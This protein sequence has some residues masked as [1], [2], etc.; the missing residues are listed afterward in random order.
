MIY[1]F[2]YLSVSGGRGWSGMNKEC[3]ESRMTE[4]YSNYPCDHSWVSLSNTKNRLHLHRIGGKKG[5]EMSVFYWFIE[6]THSTT[7]KWTVLVVTNFPFSPKV[8][9]KSL[10]LA[11]MLSSTYWVEFVTE[12][13]MG[14]I[15]VKKYFPWDFP[16]GP[17]V[18]NL[19]ANVGNM[20][21][22]PGLGRFHMSQG[23]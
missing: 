1:P 9:D 14:G 16:G 22:S 10:G 21:L 23:S 3:K 2:I 17:V 6:T 8:V 11:R 20:G 18:R 19:P 13:T 12:E 15:S 4:V 5:F 7:E